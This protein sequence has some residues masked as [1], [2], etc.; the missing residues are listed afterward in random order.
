MELILNDANSYVLHEI[1]EQME[2]QVAA[3]VAGEIGRQVIAAQM[4]GIARIR[5]QLE[6][7]AAGAGELSDG[8]REALD[9]SRDL[10]AG[11]SQFAEG[12]G[13]LRDGIGRLDAAVQELPDGVRQLK[14][15][16][17]ALRSGLDQVDGVTQEV[18]GF[19]AE[20]YGVW[21][22]IAADL[23][24]LIN[25]SAMPEPAKQALLRELDQ[26][27]QAIRQL[28]I[29]VTDYADGIDQ[30][31]K[32][33]AQLDAGIGQLEAAANNLAAAIGQLDDGV[34]ELD[35]R[36]GEIVSG[37]GALASGLEQLAGGA[38]ELTRGLEEG[39]AQLPNLT[40]EQ[41]LRF[42]EVVMNPVK[43]ATSTIAPAGT[44]AIGLAPFFM[45]LAGWIGVYILFVLMPPISTRALIANVAPWKV[46]LGGWLPLAAIGVGQMVV[47][48]AALRVIVDLTPAYLALTVA[49]LCLMVLTYLTIVH[50]LITGLGK[51]GLFLGLV[52]MV[53]QLTTSGGTFPWQTLPAIDQPLHQILPM[54][55]AVDALRNLLYGGSL[56]MAARHS[57]VLVAY[58]VVFGA[59]DVLVVRLRRRWS[60]RLLFPA[61]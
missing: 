53:V 9:G 49:F 23:R 42:A 21:G 48:L 58:F 1:A 57:L 47:M 2:S 10:A 61:I 38:D 24:A 37:V 31:D 14:A 60:M 45:A 43:F 4:D 44:Y 34:A 59:A 7:A 40:E 6:N 33:A 3:E 18:A 25:A 27:D 56:E 39:A 19:E 20:L 32:G 51:I 28:H 46:A 55:H 54:G 26:A 52:L 36:F 35:T 29:D 12:L 16:S 5:D 50:C 17:A 22:E 15:G 30:L 8:L 41:R 11:T 13:E